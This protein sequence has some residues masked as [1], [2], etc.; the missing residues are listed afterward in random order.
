MV[1]HPRTPESI[2]TTYLIWDNIVW[3]KFANVE[4]H[5]SLS[6]GWKRNRE[7]S[8][9]STEHG[10]S[11]YLWNFG[12]FPLGYTLPYPGAVFVLVTAMR[13]LN[14]MLVIQHPNN[15]CQNNKSKCSL[16]SFLIHVSSFL[17]GH[18]TVFRTLFCHFLMCSSLSMRDFYKIQGT[19]TVLN[20]LILMFLVLN[21]R[22]H[23]PKSTCL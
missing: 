13:T 17:T 22:K 9:P 3:Q 20:I 18:I 21:C 5:N 11:R 4:R 16:Y 2:E 7:W 15:T 23:F 1:S 14:L 8:Y 12:T 10:D 6:S 19:I